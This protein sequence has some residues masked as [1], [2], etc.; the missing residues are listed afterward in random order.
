MLS[1]LIQNI[2]PQS[3]L[4]PP[5]KISVTSLVRWVARGHIFPW[6]SCS[7][8]PQNSVNNFSRI[9]S[10][11]PALRLGSSGKN[12]R[13]YSHWLLVRS[14]FLNQYITYFLIWKNYPLALF[15][16]LW[17]GFHFVLGIKRVFCVT[18]VYIDI[19]YLFHYLRQTLSESY[20]G[21]NQSLYVYRITIGL[22]ASGSPLVK[23][24]YCSS[25]I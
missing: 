25:D 1:Q 9:L 3:L 7:A 6:R 20:F 18:I 14:I 8:N 11:T 2:V 12:S 22:V 13:I 16:I 10:R 24:R 21:S 5:L 4:V 15:L 23:A 17:D 19:P